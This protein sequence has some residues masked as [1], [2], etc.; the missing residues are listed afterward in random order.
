LYELTLH[1]KRFLLH[2]LDKN[3][4]FVSVSRFDESVVVAAKTHSHIVA[5]ADIGEASSAGV[6]VLVV[7]AAA[8]SNKD[9]PTVV[10]VGGS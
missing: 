6:V 1:C 10:L 3:S 8:A 5:V 7:V 4:S 9:L 2:R